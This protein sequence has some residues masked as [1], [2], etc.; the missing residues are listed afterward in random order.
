MTIPYRC[1]RCASNSP[2]SNYPSDIEDHIKLN[3]PGE[4]YVE[5]GTYNCSQCTLGPFSE[6]ESFN[7]HNRA[8]HDGNASAVPYFR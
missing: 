2:I 1:S 6:L 4:G 5:S 3:Q 7:E 8:V